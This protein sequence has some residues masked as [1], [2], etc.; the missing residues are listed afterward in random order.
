[1]EIWALE[2]LATL[3]W[4]ELMVVDD[5]ITLYD[6]QGM[7]ENSQV[8]VLLL[9]LIYYP[10]EFSSCSLSLLSSLSLLPYLWAQY[11]IA[12]IGCNFYRISSLRSI[13]TEIAYYRV[14]SNPANL[15][16]WLTLIFFKRQSAQDFFRLAPLGLL[17][18]EIFCAS[19]IILVG[20]EE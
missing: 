6:I 7:G 18:D 14:M 4:D 5:L 17:V 12:H 19:S 8:S 15:R 9:S 2:L 3:F 16:C 1:M 10:D 20:V 11:R 13:R